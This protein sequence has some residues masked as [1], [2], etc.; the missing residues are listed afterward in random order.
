[1]LFQ[2]HH[3]TASQGQVSRNGEPNGSSA[4]YEGFDVMHGVAGVSDC[5]LLTHPPVMPWL[6]FSVDAE[7]A[8]GPADEQANEWAV[9]A[10]PRV[11]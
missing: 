11:P 2:N 3:L 8:H 4:D 10:P 1:M 9:T 6:A 5:A 7:V